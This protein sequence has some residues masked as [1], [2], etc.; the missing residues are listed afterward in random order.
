VLLFDIPV[1]LL[2]VLFSGTVRSN[3]DPINEISDEKIIEVLTKTQLL[4]KILGSE[5]ET[6]TDLTDKATI[7]KI[8]SFKVENSGSNFSLGERQLL[9]LARALAVRNSVEPLNCC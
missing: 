7:E 5:K 4:G 8:L 6:N 3:I 1:H 9:C 2:S